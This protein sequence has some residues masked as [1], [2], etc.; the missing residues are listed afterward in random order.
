MQHAP[1]L[2]LSPRN[3]ALSPCGRGMLLANEHSGTVRVMAAVTAVIALARRSGRL[4]LEKTPLA[5]GPA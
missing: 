2:G 3:F 1:S 5:G 4:S